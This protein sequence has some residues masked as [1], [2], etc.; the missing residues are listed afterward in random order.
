MASW[1]EGPSKLLTTS[2]LCGQGR[3]S[4][5]SRQSMWSPLSSVVSRSWEA[6][7]LHPETTVPVLLLTVPH[8]PPLKHIGYAIILVVQMCQKGF[9]LFWATLLKCKWILKSNLNFWAM[10]TFRVHQLDCSQ[11][12]LW[13]ALGESGAKREGK[14]RAGDALSPLLLHSDQSSL[15]LPEPV[16]ALPRKGVRGVWKP[17]I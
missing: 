14:H 15:L 6:S 11:T 5:T 10:R 2:M 17:L 12:V 8:L 1:R 16:L 7:A 4:Y 9:S 13:G 3:L